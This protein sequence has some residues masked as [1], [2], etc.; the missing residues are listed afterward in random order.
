M[1]AM[2]ELPSRVE[3][4]EPAKVFS[5]IYSNEFKIL[6]SSNLITIYVKFCIQN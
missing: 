4:A 2:A 6:I 5:C 3:K 1:K